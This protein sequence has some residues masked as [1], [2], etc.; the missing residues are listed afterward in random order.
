MTSTSVCRLEAVSDLQVLA[1][2]DRAARHNPADGV[3]AFRLAEHLGL[4]HGASTTR[5]LR[6]QIER[7]IGA[8]ELVCTRC[9]GHRALS[10]TSKGSR[11]LARARRERRNLDLPESPQ[12]QRWRIVQD[13]ASN[14]IDEFRHELAT[15]L[16]ATR[17]LLRA[18]EQDFKAAL[19]LLTRLRG[20]CDRFAWAMYCLSEWAEPDDAHAD[21]DISTRQREVHLVGVTLAG[22]ALS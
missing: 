3:P 19:E 17:R 8:G 2:I 7:L 20:Q 6:P 5:H 9:H 14:R 16:T 18:G 22:G 11:R 10:L 4:R 15:T 1:A 13:E 21:I 12:H